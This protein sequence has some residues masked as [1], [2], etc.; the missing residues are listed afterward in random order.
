[1]A[2][3]LDR[4]VTAEIDGDFVVFLIGMRINRPWNVHKWLPVLMAMPRML[5]ELDA[6]PAE[7]G[8]LGTTSLGLTTL[9]QYWRSFDHLERY[10]RAPNKAHWPAWADFNR[11]FKA[12]RGEVGIWHETYLVR[13]GEYESV[14]SG[15]PLFGLAKAARSADV[16]ATT[17]GARDRLGVA[18]P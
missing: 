12:S 4:R 15:M 2:A 3:I 11:R 8:C 5:K 14:Y 7:S 6:A 1:M 13:A 16:A 10:A 18:P 9:V 17:D